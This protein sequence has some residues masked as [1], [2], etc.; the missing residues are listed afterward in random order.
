MGLGNLKKAI[1][2]AFETFNPQISKGHAQQ[3]RPET[4]K[5]PAYSRAFRDPVNFPIVSL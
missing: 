2:F 1:T 4:T 5:K 3:K